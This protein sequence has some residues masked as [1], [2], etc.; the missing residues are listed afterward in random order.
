MS[1]R[2]ALLIGSS[3]YEDP[4][5]R[6]SPSASFDIQRLSGLLEDPEIGDFE[7]AT[8]IDPT[9]SQARVHL[10]RF[11]TDREP[12]DVLL[13]YF[14]GLAALDAHDNLYL[15]FRD[16]DQGLLAATGVGASFLIGLL[17][18]CRAE[19]KVLILES[20]YS[21]GV[22]R[23]ALSIPEGLVILAASGPHEYAFESTE[24]GANI[25]TY[26]LS[27][28]L[29]TGEADINSDG[30]VTFEE[31]LA[32]TKR[33]VE[34]REQGQRP[35]LFNLAEYP[36][37]AAKVAR[38]IFISYSRADTIFAS[39]IRDKLISSGHK[40]WLDENGIS[41]GQNWHVRIGAAI[42]EAKAVVAILSPDAFGSTWVERELSY[43]DKVRKPIFPI[44]CRPSEIPGWYE[45][46]FGNLQ[47]L[48]FTG[49]NQQKEF[50]ALLN[51]IQRTLRLRSLSGG[52]SP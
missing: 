24:Q 48:D 5:F 6:E 3:S 11:C 45:L 17:E 4:G 34:T 9:W 40:A 10:A 37:V 46:Q 7:V 8:H 27:E 31:L 18:S 35:R 21:G 22:L 39:D 32:Y 43:A 38:H 29:R 49:A 26:Y 36:I 41:G 52:S 13:I 33:R 15:C 47:R 51:S 2:Y 44:T 23:G 25:F 50:E 14:T 1:A 16:T 12:E 42:D 20:V 30:D 28:G 19:R